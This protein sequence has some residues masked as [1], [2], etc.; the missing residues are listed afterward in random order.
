M[1]FENIWPFYEFVTHPKRATC[2]NYHPP[3]FNHLNTISV[4][5]EKRIYLCGGKQKN[6]RIS[7][8]KCFGKGR[9]KVK[10]L[11][12]EFLICDI[13]LT[14][15]CQDRITRNFSKFPP[16]FESHIL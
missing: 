5:C 7:V 11:S 12:T 16:G 9:H 1:C 6:I 2:L 3:W 14:E 8:K 13:G 10:L 4:C 15:L